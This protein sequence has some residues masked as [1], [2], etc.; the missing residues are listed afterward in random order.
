[1]L[2]V[3]ERLGGRGFAR[4]VPLKGGLLVRRKGRGEGK[5]GRGKEGKG[6]DV[7][8][9]LEPLRT[10]QGVSSTLITLLNLSS[11]SVLSSASESE[12]GDSYAVIE[13]VRE[14]RSVE[15]TGWNWAGEA[16]WCMKEVRARRRSVPVSDSGLGSSD[17]EEGEEG[18]EGELRCASSR[19]VKTLGVHACRLLLGA[20]SQ[21]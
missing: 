17:E 11:L 13:E 20:C 9:I 1:M 6:R 7:R 16:E 3:L 18:E 10:M 21:T 19:L 2:W 15:E 12:L 8:G 5:G 14:E 4:G